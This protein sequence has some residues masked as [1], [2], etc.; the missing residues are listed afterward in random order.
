LGI[1]PRIYE[2][3]ADRVVEISDYI[4]GRRACTNRDFQDPTVRKAVVV[5]YRAFNDSGKLPLT[6]T[7]FWTMAQVDHFTSASARCTARRD[8]IS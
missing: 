2:Y 6:K 5:L 4:E 1:G 3:L 7:T 8:F